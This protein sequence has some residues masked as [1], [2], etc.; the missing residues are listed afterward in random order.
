MQCTC[1]FF[2]GKS[3]IANYW[4]G[5]PGYPF[6]N[7]Q[8]EYKNEREQVILPRCFSIGGLEALTGF[9]FGTN[10]EQAVLLT[11]GSTEKG[12]GVHDAEVILRQEYDSQSFRLLSYKNTKP[13]IH[14]G[15]R[16]LCIGLLGSGNACSCLGVSQKISTPFARNL[17]FFF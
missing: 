13:P 14:Q 17:Q 10:Q 4:L 9:P 5:S 16:L 8:N 2:V 15:L 6:P 1:G 11:P 12:F 3:N 7:A